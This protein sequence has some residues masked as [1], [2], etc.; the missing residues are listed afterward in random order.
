[1][2]SPKRPPPT[3]AG[4]APNPLIKYSLL[5]HGAELE[6]N[7]TEQ[8]PLLGSVC[9]TGQA[10]VWFG[11]YGT[12]KSLIFNHLL[13]EAIQDR[14]VEG[15]RVIIINAD[16][17]SAGLAQK[18]RLFQDYGVH[19]LAPGFQGFRAS[20]LTGQLTEMTAFDA[21]SGVVVVLDTFKK[22][23]DVMEKRGMRAF[24][25]VIREF[26]LQGG[27]VL[28]LAHTNKRPGP[29]GKP[30]PEGTA[31]ALSDFD[32]SFL[33]DTVKEDKDTGEVI[34]EFAKVKSRGPVA[35]K[36]YYLYDPDPQLS[37]IERLAS[38]RKVDPKDEKYASRLEPPS[39]DDVVIERIEGCMEH[40]VV[41][42]M[43]IVRTAAVAAGVSRRTALRVLEQYTG[44]DPDVHR[45]NFTRREHGR[46]VYAPL[47]PPG[48]G[49]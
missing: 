34:I 4:T 32:C 40:G 17:D 35:L 36:E 5:G 18:V 22:F 6:K 38:V 2:E 25:I 46:M 45:W 7:A 43:D 16:D 13:I 10:T 48:E 37:Y 15:E 14:R 41:T 24:N 31:D 23:V 3:K 8:K 49:N 26:V 30:I 33:L 27:T 39:D 20:M 44:D 1:M 9:L 42:K 21:A 19:V 47:A 28:A 12:G 11:R 29:D